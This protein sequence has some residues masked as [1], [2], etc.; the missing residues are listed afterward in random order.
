VT[1]SSD[2][3]ADGAEKDEA[4]R[5]LINWLA[6]DLAFGVETIARVPE[7]APPEPGA[8]SAPSRTTP[9]PAPRAPAPRSSTPRPSA[10]PAARSGF[11]PLVA[12][13]AERLGATD[14]RARLDALDAEV[15]GCTSCKLHQGRTLAVPGEG[16]VEADLMFIGEG[17]GADEDRTG[18]PFVGRAGE[19]LTKIIEAMGF[20][21]E[22]VFIANIVKCRPPGN[23]DPEPDET[24]SCFPYLERQLEIIEPKVIC[25]L[26]LPATRKLLD[27][28]G[29][30]TA[31]RGKKFVFRGIPLIPTFHPAYLLRSPAGKKPVWQDMQTVARL[32][33]ERGGVIPNRAVFD[34]NVSA[35]R[36]GPPSQREE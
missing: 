26:G 14:R 7:R 25:T 23:R 5:S 29:G 4:R 6:S 11:R 2:R 30:I 12:P 32:V 22:S 13:L 9:E 19:L 34:R 20:S 16:N 28:R 27:M 21:R 31:L 24:T 33:E 17:P 10:P 15:A 1:E 3:A 18:R 36:P 35:S 8:R